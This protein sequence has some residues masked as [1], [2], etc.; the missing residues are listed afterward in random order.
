M[1]EGTDGRNPIDVVMTA[2]AAVGTG[3]GL[4]R[5]AYGD[6]IIIHGRPRS[7]FDD[8]GG[9]HFDFQAE[10]RRLRHEIDRQ[11]KPKAKR[12]YK[13]SK[14]AKRASRKHK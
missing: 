7:L 12:P 8:L 13:G 11:K 1:S 9:L 3:G 10:R 5:S 6:A 14:A 2:M 4:F